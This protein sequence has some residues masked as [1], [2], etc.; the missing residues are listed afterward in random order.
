MY[1]GPESG[2]VVFHSSTT[3]RLR[4]FKF[5]FKLL[6]KQQ[7]TYYRKPIECALEASSGGES[8]RR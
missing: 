1:L 8:R 4:P 7:T 5:K 3:L 2:R 6:H